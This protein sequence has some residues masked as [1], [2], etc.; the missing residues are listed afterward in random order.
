MT[1]ATE[2]EMLDLLH[3]RFGQKSYNGGI[4]APRYICAEHV[5]TRAGFY[6]R[7]ID[8]VAVETWESSMRAGTL[9]IHG[10]EVKVSRSD[11][12]R[13]LKDPHK[14]AETMEYATH[15]WLAVPDLTVARPEEL[16]DGWGLLHIVG[17]R[18]LVAKV[19]ARRR[20]VDPLSPSATA[21]LLRAAAKTAATWTRPETYRVGESRSAT[22]QESVAGDALFGLEASA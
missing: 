22:V 12:L 19:T 20:A 15:C 21:G 17:S 13:E 10:A 4:E 2:R 14:T 18:G 11:W 5:R 9:T 7:E 16:P 1:A 8:F 3:K 6:C